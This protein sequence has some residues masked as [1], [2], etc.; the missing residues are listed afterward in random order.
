M[1]G[2]PNTLRQFATTVL[3]LLLMASMASAAVLPSKKE[4]VP[5][6]GVVGVVTKVTITANV[7]EGGSGGLIGP[8]AKCPSNQEIVGVITTSGP[9]TVRY[10]FLGYPTR[11]L[12]FS[13]AGSKRVSMNWRLTQKSQGTDLGLETLSPNKVTATTALIFT[14]SGPLGGGL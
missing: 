11:A 2:S 13:T 5:R 8:V 1:S 14:C 6:G 7:R 12:T 9:T 3:G 10:R 4:E